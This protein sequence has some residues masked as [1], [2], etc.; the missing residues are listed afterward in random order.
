LTTTVVP[1]LQA[2]FF[3]YLFGEQVGYV[4]VAYANPD[5]TQFR[6]TFYEW[7]KQ[8][9]DLKSFISKA[10]FQRNMW[11]CVNL[12]H[13]PERKKENCLPCQLVWADLDYMDYEDIKPRP[14][15]IIKSS[16]GRFQAFWRLDG[17]VPADV[18]ED[19]SRKIAY[20]LGA[21]KSGWDLTQLLRIPLTTNY[22]YDEQPEVELVYAD[23]ERHAIE[24]FE[25]IKDTSSVDQDEVPTVDE[26]APDP[27]ALPSIDQILYKKLYDIQRTA[28]F[29]EL[30]ENDPPQGADWS[31]MLWRLINLCFE[32]GMEKEEVFVIAMHAKCNK[33]ERD[34]RPVSYLWKEVLKA[35]MLQTRVNLISSVGFLKTLTMP[36]LV[37]PG[38]VKGLEYNFISEYKR[39]ASGATDAIEEYHELS[40]FILLSAILS[41][42]LKLTTNWGEI[43]PN[44]WGM[45]LGESTLTRKTTAMRMVMDMISDI[46]Q[47]MI[48]ATDGSVEGLLTGLADRPRR[49]SIFYK[50][51]VSGFFDSINR[52][53]YLAGMPETLTQLYDVPKVLTRLLRRETI[54]IS[55]PYFIFF[56]GGI[57]DKVYSLL[58]DE[59]VLSGFIP[60]FLVVSGNTDL[61]KLRQTGPPTEHS[62]EARQKIVDRIC[63]LYEIYNKEAE[64]KIGNQVSS[65]PI[66]FDARLTDRAWER[67]GMMENL[68]V[69]EASDTPLAT[70]ALPTFTRL[71]FSVLKMAVLLSASRREPDDAHRVYV[72]VEDVLQAAHYVQRWGRHTIDLI[73]NVG[74]SED[75]KTLDRVLLTIKQNPGIT[76]SALMQR[77]HLMSRHANEILT[78]LN[79]R[80]IILTKKEGRGLKFWPLEYVSKEIEGATNEK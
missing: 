48:L 20:K 66:R 30:L 23:E 11:F 46:D 78:T 27:L 51:E 25:Q 4:C 73:Q 29:K 5:K 62:T 13:S 26:P 1:N 59:Y 55:S 28:G 80:G 6:Q 21:D 37:R 67:Y 47:S 39:W 74:R 52:K 16:S 71:G 69:R 33:Y 49:T 15:C 24:V 44:L 50:D 18:A 72:E 68:L 31:R 36:D 63:D 19:F 61:E 54:T 42:G 56:G 35:E 34:N 38:E 60:R 76:K 64:F 77:H 10:S 75:E 43:I 3:E 53:D 40:A 14:S 2:Q 9:A 65:T 12:L 58:N 79:E 22:K 45:V 32:M 70:I 8:K 57:R 17:Y 41:T 7:P